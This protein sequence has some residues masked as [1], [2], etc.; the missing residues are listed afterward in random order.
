MKKH[1]RSVLTLKDENDL[2]YE[3]LLLYHPYKNIVQNLYRLS[4]DKKANL[5]DPIS[6]EFNGID[7]ADEYIKYYYEALLGV[8]SYFQASKGGRGKY[9]EKKLA[10]V[11]ESCCLN[12]KLS[13]LHH[14]LNYIEIIRKKKLSGK[15]SLS[16]EETKKILLS[17][18]N[19]IAEE[20]E[21]TDLCSLFICDGSISFLELKNR[22]DSGGTAA[23]REIY[24]T[25]FRKILEYFI[26]SKPIFRLEKK[27]YS[28]LEF[29]HLFW[30][31]EDSIS[32]W[33]F[34]QYQW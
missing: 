19:F 10:S 9:I 29:I 18:W 11:S 6:R 4:T 30:Y 27:T 32:T 34:I 14:L 24:D 22:I 20:D 33:N 5:F 15:S 1:E 26:N 13:E 7:N 8:T 16:E 12:S 3:D 21:T 23:R 25:K 2:S 17:K 31:K 28:L